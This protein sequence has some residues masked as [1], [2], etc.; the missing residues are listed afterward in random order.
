MKPMKEREQSV[1]DYIA[2]TIR[3]N[4]Y[5]PSVRDIK[6]ALGF[7]STSTVHMYLEKLEERGLLHKVSGKSRTLRLGT[8]EAKSSPVRI[9]ILGDV[10]AG[11]LTF[12]EENYDGYIDFCV[13]AGVDRELLFALYVK[14]ES[15]KDAG[16]LDGDM[17]VVERTDY[18]ENGEIV[19]ALVENET[20]VKRYFKENGK[21]RLQPHND[22][23]K[24]II[25]DSVMIIGRVIAAMRTY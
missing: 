1:Y 20:T 14:G 16:I 6:E 18:A 3:E 12:A 2:S 19:V 13:G 9:P 22:A 23:F 8:E 15:M 21:F 25:L 4:G 10:A 17:L 5:S 24:P 7:K 11:E